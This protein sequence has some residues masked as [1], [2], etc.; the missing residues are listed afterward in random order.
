[1]HFAG[2]G[3]SSDG[4]INAASTSSS[5]VQLPLGALVGGAAGFVVLVL[6]VACLTYFLVCRRRLKVQSQGPVY[7]DLGS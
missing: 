3:G 4:A 6:V 5:F 7:G 2:G 1:M